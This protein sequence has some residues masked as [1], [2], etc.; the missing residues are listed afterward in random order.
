M[1]AEMV[2]GGIRTYARLDPAAAPTFA[3]WK[4][5]VRAG[6]TFATSGPVIDLSVDGHEPGSVIALPPKGGRVEAI[7]RARAAQ[8]VIDSVE[9]VVNGR[10]VASQDAVEGAD[11]MKLTA[12]I[13]IDSSSW[14]AARSR[15]AHV[16]GS[17][18][19]DEHGLAHIPG[20]CGCRGPT[21]LRPGRRG[22]DRRR[23]RW[24]RPVAREDGDDRRPSRP[25]ADGRPDQGERRHA[26]TTRRP[27]PIGGVLT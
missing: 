11:D 5:A 25:G 1:S 8:A 21:A 12:T 15:S 24:H 17:A 13:E 23:H 7:V 10:V 6:R 26:S 20:V 4:D 18:S 19:P 14:I 27:R 22:C 3:A 2:L 16:V 9:L